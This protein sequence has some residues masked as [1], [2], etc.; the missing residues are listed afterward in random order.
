MILVLGESHISVDDLDTWVPATGSVDAS[1]ITLR[2]R[3]VAGGALQRRA[4]GSA[5]TWVAMDRDDGSPADAA[6]Y[7]FSLADLRAGKIGFLAGDGT[8]PITFT[9]QAEDDQGNLSD[10]DS[11]N[12]GEQP[13][14]IRIPVVGLVKVGIGETI[15]VN[16]DGALTPLEATLDLWRGAAAGGALTILVELHGGS[17]RQRSFFWLLGMVLRVL[18]PRG[19]GTRRVRL[20]LF[21]WRTSVLRALPNFRAMLDVLQLRSAVG[22]SDSYRRI[23][24]RPDISGSAFK[25]DFHVREVKVSVNDAPQAPAGGLADQPVDEDATATLYVSQVSGQGGRC[26]EQG[27]HIWCEVGCRWCRAGYSYWSLDRV[28]QGYADFYVCSA[29]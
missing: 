9:I 13:A 17:E 12:S 24:V 28:R 25:K 3:D 19:V 8:N 4:S 16:L 7:S 27:P 22:A 1:R 14:S 20:E 15:S 21:L 11:D 29:R 26:G 2:V 5:T 18:R 10:S 6:V 23:L